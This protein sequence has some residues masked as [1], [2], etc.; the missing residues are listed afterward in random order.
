[1]NVGGH[2]IHGPFPARLRYFGIAAAASFLGVVFLLI[3]LQTDRVVCPARG[4]CTHDRVTFDRSELRGVHVEHRS[5]AKNAK[6]GVLVLDLDAGRRVEMM[7]VEPDEA[8][9]AAARIRGAIA[10]DAAFDETVRQPRWLAPVGATGIVLALV[11]LGLGLSKMG[12]FDLFIENGK[13]FVRRSLFAIPLGT[14]QVPLDR[15]TEVRVE[16][17][18]VPNI[19]RQRFEKGLAAGRLCLV[20][21]GG[22]E[23]PL[24]DALFPGHALHLRAASALRSALGLE[25]NTLDDE[26]LSKIPMRTW[27]ASMRFAHAWM[28][29]TTGSLVG[30][31][32][33][34]LSLLLFKM[35][36]FHANIEGWM[37]AGG[38]G[39]GAI[40]GAAIALHATRPRLP[41]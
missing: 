22:E 21:R 36:S 19:L 15:V 3:G 2:V 33:F 1:M 18:M 8:E 9:A 6:Y 38:G 26:E 14:R 16:R 10:S 7:Q 29:V 40:A 5:G 30:M 27:P 25:A 12:R 17:G 32:L 41:R 11:V 20:S 34:G 37:V 4:T 28:G 35:T 23:R 31:M 13:L 39:G 24:T